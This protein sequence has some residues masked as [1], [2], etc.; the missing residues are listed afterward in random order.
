M[1]FG[2]VAISE[3][4]GIPFIAEQNASPWI[5]YVNKNSVELIEDEK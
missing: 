4:N 1:A 3:A 2:Y 5:I